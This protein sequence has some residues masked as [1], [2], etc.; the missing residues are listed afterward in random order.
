MNFVPK[1][2]PLRSIRIMANHA[3][4]KTDRL[5]ARPRQNG[6]IEWK[7]LPRPEVAAEAASW[8]RR[9]MIAC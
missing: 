4:V 9:A 8:H 1:S 6:V 3:L 5:F 2:H 7:G